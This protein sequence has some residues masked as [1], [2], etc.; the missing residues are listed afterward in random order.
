LTSVPSSLPHSRW[1]PTAPPFPV[2]IIPFKDPTS[3]LPRFYLIMLFFCLSSERAMDADFSAPS[4][5]NSSFFQWLSRHYTPTPL[6]VGRLYQRLPPIVEVVS[7]YNPPPH[8]PF[9]FSSALP[10]PLGLLSSIHFILLQMSSFSSGIN[11]APRP[12]LP[13]LLIT[14]LPATFPAIP[15]AHSGFFW[16][17]LPPPSRGIIQPL[18]NVVFGNLIPFFPAPLFLNE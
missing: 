4:L 18:L 5:S 14:F 7:P 11:P 17:L 1:A 2:V 16:C 13:V 9:F 6:S 3:C 10:P 12:L 15:R 8:P